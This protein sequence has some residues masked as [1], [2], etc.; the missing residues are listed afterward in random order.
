MY[1][2]QPK[3]EIKIIKMGDTEITTVAG[4]ARFLGVHPNTI[5]RWEQSGLIAALRLPSGVRR[6]QLDELQR[7]RG[8]MIPDLDLAHLAKAVKKLGEYSLGNITAEQAAPE[9]T[10]VGS[11]PAIN[12]SQQIYDK[13]T[14]RP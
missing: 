11:Q 12:I 10:F 5:R 3:F 8:E 9:V 14:Q 4:A 13:L 1:E 2:M 7:V 6:F